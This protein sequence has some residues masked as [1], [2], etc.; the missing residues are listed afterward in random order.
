MSISYKTVGLVYHSLTDRNG[1]IL[2]ICFRPVGFNSYEVEI[3]YLKLLLGVKEYLADFLLE[4][5][6]SLNVLLTYFL[7]PRKYF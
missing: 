6:N 2:A 1:M 5:R 7:K 4:Y 3:N